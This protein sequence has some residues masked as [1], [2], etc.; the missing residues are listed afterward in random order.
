MLISASLEN[1]SQL[2]MWKTLVTAHCPLR[3][4]SE[5]QDSPLMTITIITPDN[6]LLFIRFP[7]ATFD[8]R[9]SMVN[10]AGDPQNNGV[11]QNRGY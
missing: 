9:L 10:E 8:P 5:Q 11:N 7:L 6:C 3:N 1:N 4:A 2:N